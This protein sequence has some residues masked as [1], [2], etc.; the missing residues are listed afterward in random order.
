[1]KKITLFTLL[2]STYTFAQVG[3]ET[4][5]AVTK[6]LNVKFECFLPNLSKLD[7]ATLIDVYYKSSPFIQRAQSFT[8]IIGAD[9]KLKLTY[10]NE[11]GKL[12]FLTEASSTA[13]TEQR[14]FA[15][16]TSGQISG[17]VLLQ[18]LVEKLKSYHQKYFFLFGVN[19][20][21]EPTPDPLQ[22]AKWF[23]N[24]GGRGSFSLN[25]RRNINVGSS[26]TLSYL[27][28]K[29]VNRFL[30]YGGYSN[31]TY[32]ELADGTVEEPYSNTEIAVTN[33]LGM[34]L[35][36]K[37]N[38]ALIMI[39]HSTPNGENLDF[40]FSI[41]PGIQ[42]NLVPIQGTNQG[43]VGFAVRFFYR[44]QDYHKPNVNDDLKDS[45][46]MNRSSF[47]VSWHFQRVDVQQNFSMDLN[48][49]DTKFF[50]LSSNT[51]F[52][53]RLNKK[54]NILFSPRANIGYRPNILKEPKERA[55]EV[56]QQLATSGSFSKWDITTGASI[57]VFL[58]NTAKNAQDNRW[59][60]PKE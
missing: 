5:Q 15:F 33:T 19:E 42:W 46:V 53:F 40:E 12:V 13:T 8:E 47:F 29:F 14:V 9:L 45:F 10:R 4:A 37:L 50:E 58:G 51:S 49:N 18:N 20:E 28:D 6:K 16:V 60:I 27:D 54:G 7:C 23:A 1:M 26:F 36:E 35:T 44:Y 21:G 31:E 3:T 30:L 11:A 32:P 17:D 25:D 43:N 22:E 48:L 56:L 24:L 39:G 59:K 52:E 57:R 34:N 55:D 2:I 41:G 38:A